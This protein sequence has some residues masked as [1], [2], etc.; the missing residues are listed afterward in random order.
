MSDHEEFNVEQNEIT[1]LDSIG[2]EVSMP[3]GVDG[4]GSEGGDITYGEGVPATASKGWMVIVAV[5]ILAAGGLFAMQRLAKVTAGTASDATID[6]RIEKFLSQMGG[7]DGTAGELVKGISTVT[8]VLADDY[9]QL[10]VPLKQ[11]Q[12][13]PFALNRDESQEKTIEDDPAADAARLLRKQRDKRRTEIEH[14]CDKIGLKSVMMG[15]V[16]LANISGKI[17]RLGEPLTIEGIKFKVSKI[18][19]DRVKLTARDKK[20]NLVVDVVLELEL[21]K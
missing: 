3:I 1:E 10:Q 13:N 15:K 2:N 5:I 19:S 21:S 7:N 14:A 18:S 20:F 11:V 6:G 16:P 4:F 9:S 8:T 17:V 12:F